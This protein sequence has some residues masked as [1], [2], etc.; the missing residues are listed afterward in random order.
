VLEFELVD[1]KEL[2][3]MQHLIDRFSSGAHGHG[4]GDAGGGEERAGK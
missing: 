1:A 3:P 4:H 2:T